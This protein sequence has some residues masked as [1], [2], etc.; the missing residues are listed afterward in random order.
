MEARHEKVTAGIAPRLVD[1]RRAEHA[2]VRKWLAVVSTA[3]A[4]CAHDLR[5][6]LKLEVPLRDRDVPPFSSA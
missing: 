4:P 5:E 3:T 2:P 1:A 6:P